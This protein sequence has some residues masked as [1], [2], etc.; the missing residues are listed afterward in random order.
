[1]A[2]YAGAIAAW[3]E[4]AD[5]GSAKN[6]RPD[7]LDR[8]ELMQSRDFVPLDAVDQVAITLTCGEGILDYASPRQPIR[9]PD[10]SRST[11]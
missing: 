8:M 3:E 4:S 6:N 1:M 2:P 9:P 5:I 10:G 11:P 7:L